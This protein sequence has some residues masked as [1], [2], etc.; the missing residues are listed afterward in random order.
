MIKK[1]RM[2][3]C[4]GSFILLTACAPTFKAPVRSEASS[5][6]QMYVVRS[7]DTLYSIAKKFNV[8]PKQLITNNR[9]TNANKI[10]VGQKLHISQGTGIKSVAQTQTKQSTS[11][12]KR[13]TKS[14]QITAAKTTKAQPVVSNASMSSTQSMT[15]KASVSKIQWLRPTTG[16]IVRRFNPSLPGHKGIQIAGRLGQPVIAAASGKVVYAGSGHPGYGQLVILQHSADV[17]SAYGYLLEIRVRE[18]QNINAGQEIAALGQST[19][20]RQVL[21]FEIRTGGQ[22]VDPQLYLP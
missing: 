17:Y 11:Q 13:Q 18:G 6:Q 2:T 5:T 15:K 7:G 16:N 10:Q 20:Q 8:S 3:G 12:T 4:I 14:T 21:H 1:I 9:I 19:D 22:P